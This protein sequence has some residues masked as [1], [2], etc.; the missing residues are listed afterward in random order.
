MRQDHNSDVRDVF[1]K[2]AAKLEWGDPKDE[3]TFIGPVMSEK[4][5]QRIEEWVEE[6]VECGVACL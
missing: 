4:E 3:E 2:E 5:A 1:V 6:A